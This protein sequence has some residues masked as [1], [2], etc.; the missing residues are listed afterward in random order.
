L[1]KYRLS[2]AQAGARGR[3]G[4]DVALIQY[5]SCSESIKPSLQFFCNFVVINASEGSFCFQILLLIQTRRNIQSSS[6][7]KWFKE[8]TDEVIL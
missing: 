7:F 5:P 6:Q 1:L 4:R 2:T 3:E 8:K